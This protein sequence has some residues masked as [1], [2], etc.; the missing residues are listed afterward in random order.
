MRKKVFYSVFIANIKSKN[1]FRKEILWE[2]YMEL[3]VN[4]NLKCNNY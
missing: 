4:L 3:L 2:I 1:I